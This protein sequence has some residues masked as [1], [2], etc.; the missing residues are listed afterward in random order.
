MNT[1]EQMDLIEVLKL[2]E[3]IYKG[4]EII[5][6]DES[7]K[8]LQ[9]KFSNIDNGISLLFKALSLTSIGGSTITEEIHKSAA[10]YLKNILLKECSTFGNEVIFTYIKKLCELLIIQNKVNT[11][12]NIP[13]IYIV[14]H[15]TINNLLSDEKIVSN[16][17]YLSELFSI[18]LKSISSE[19]KENFIQTATTCILLTT[20]FLNS[21]SANKYNYEEILN[22]FYI[23]IVNKV[24]ANTPNFLDIK[25]NKYNDDFII[26]LKYLYDG[27][28]TNLS[29]I[30]SVLGFK[31][32]KEIAF[33]FFRE[34]GLYSY[35]LIELMPPFDE[36]TAKKYGKPNPIIVFDVDE[37]KCYEINHMKS[38]VLQFF[39][40]I[41]QISNFEERDIG[42]EKKLII[43]DKEL[44][45][46]VNKI[47]NLIEKSFEDIVNNKE[48][49]YFIKKYKET[50]NEEDDYYNV[51]LFQIFVFLTRSLI[52]EPIMTEFSKRIKQFLLN[53]L[54]PL[55]ITI[56]DEK[57]FLEKNPEEYH[58]YINE[59]TNEFKRK[60]FRTSGCFLINKICEKYDGMSN[61]I[62]SFCLEMF[63][64][65]INDGNITNKVV[66]YNVYL[67]YN[68]EA[69]INQFDDKIKIDFALLI[70]I[71]L[72][73]KVQKIHYIQNRLREIIINNQDKIHLISSPIIKIKICKIYNY[74]L[75]KFVK[76]SNEFDY[77]SND[78][79]ENAINFLLNNIIQ[80]DN[81]GYIQALSYEAS[82]TIIELLALPKG[83]EYEENE[84]IIDYISQYLEEN[85]GIFNNL[86]ET[87]NINSFFLVIEHILN[88]I[89]IEQKNLV[90][91]C[92]TNL[93]KKYQKH[94]L[95][96]S[97][98]QKSFCNQYFHILES[99]LTGANKLNPNNKE[100]LNKFNE[101]FDPIL[102]YIKNPNIFLMYEEL[103]S[104]TEIYI[105]SLDGIN[106]RSALVLKN[107]KLILDKEQTISNITFNFVS[108]FILYINK[109]ISE[110]PLDQI[111]LVNEILIIIKK[112]FS[113]KETYQISK[114]Y[115]LLLILQILNLNLTFSEDI[116]DF[117]I[118]QS[119]NSFENAD[120]NQDYPNEELNIKQLS[121][122]NISL[123]F[124]FKPDLSFKVLQ[125]TTKNSKDKEIISFD[126]FCHLLGFLLNLS[127]PNY[128][129]LLGKCIILGICEI[130]RDKT[131]LDYLN[132]K[133]D[134]KLFLL[135]VFINLM[136][137]HKIEKTKI[138]NKLMKKEVKCNFVD[139]DNEEE[140]PEEEEEEEEDKNFDF[141]K[142]I[143]TI[144]SEN[145]KINNYDE[146]KYYTQVMQ[147]IKDNEPEIYQYFLKETSSGKTNIMEELFKIRNIQITFH[148]KNFIVPRKTVKIVKGNK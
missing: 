109:N 126:K 39:S 145:E 50:I 139:E 137:V 94:F 140:E 146:F 136:I 90:F 21:K 111:V 130:L 114:E 54:F 42:E 106:E 7:I 120:L 112:C 74:F 133:K 18:L 128:N 17:K 122:A 72:K 116:F 124:I 71:L 69:L 119:L 110:E 121:L 144:F 5:K 142:I 2:V 98:E 48:K 46:F 28:Y 147:I 58:N 89:K 62:L 13:A 52:R 70:I 83:E 59:I 37:E 95:G 40:F 49:F 125:K 3:E 79:D 138:M 86:I 64:Y 29:K 6:I 43:N 105:K 9:Q 60:Y 129:P 10:I 63:N 66:E 93:S 99:F 91:E 132:L 36:S 78:I 77:N 19:I 22:D 127:Y 113:F 34:Y 148:N 32:R 103:V 68:K 102:N 87:V 44:I 85:F 101:I 38:K 16:K 75:P 104:I 23:P 82:D 123:G 67:Q 30:G 96:Q 115:G 56:E 108:T 88:N 1:Q 25:N 12:L 24:F 55:M 20:T 131:C 61:F 97:E 117:L 26:L 27:L 100:E 80:K 57:T 143:E 15:K 47:L 35:E 134:N 65:I 53:I 11:H 4:K 92:L 73:N 31:K 33:K 81:N 51:L 84:F 14:I 141:N 135:K 107:I 45:E 76:N 8:I 41:T 118:N